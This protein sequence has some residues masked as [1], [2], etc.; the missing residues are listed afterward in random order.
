MV[1]PCPLFENPAPTR[2]SRLVV[3]HLRRVDDSDDAFLGVRASRLEAAAIPAAPA[4]RSGCHS[5]GPAEISGY[6]PWGGEVRC[7]A[8]EV[9]TQRPAPA[10]PLAGPGC[11]AQRP[12]GGSGAGA[13]VG[14]N[15][16]GQLCEGGGNPTSVR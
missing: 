12:K 15:W 10:V 5:G 13:T 14:V 8:A 7:S 9:I 16:R 11:A 4:P 2:S 1:S 6:G 3:V